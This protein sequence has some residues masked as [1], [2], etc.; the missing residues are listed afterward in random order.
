[1]NTTFAQ[2]PESAP[3]GDP[4]SGDTSLS[5]AAKC[6]REA[7]TAKPLPKPDHPPPPLP[8]HIFPP[9]T[10]VTRRL[11]R[12]SEE[13]ST[14]TSALF[15]RPCHPRHRG[16]FLLAAATSPQHAITK[17]PF[18]LRHHSVHG[19]AISKRRGRLNST[20]AREHPHPPRTPCAMLQSLRY[21]SVRV[22]RLAG[23]NTRPREGGF[24]DER[25]SVAVPELLEGQLKHREMGQLG[26]KSRTS[27]RSV[28]TALAV[29]T[30]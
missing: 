1:M 14:R 19:T 15:Q 9:T 13:S 26:T 4:L 6:T 18:A 5:S 20:G 29:G 25:R 23:S 2:A 8:G 21:L 17:P 22:K 10:V 30:F 27:R 24:W 16:C 11:D 3:A 7:H 12:R 28:S